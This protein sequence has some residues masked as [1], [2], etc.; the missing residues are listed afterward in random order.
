MRIFLLPRKY[1]KQQY[2]I[3]AV[4][5][6]LSYFISFPAMA[7]GENLKNRRKKCEELLGK[8]QRFAE[9]N[10]FKVLSLSLHEN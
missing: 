8:E 3:A 6:Y 1:F 4:G 7:D 5:T 9:R 2:K 10:Y